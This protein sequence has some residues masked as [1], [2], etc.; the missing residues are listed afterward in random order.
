MSRENDC[1]ADWEIREYRSGDERRLVKLFAKVYRRPLSQEVW[2]WK[3]KASASD[4]ENVWLA[5][6]RE[7]QTIF[8]IAGIPRRFLLD[9]DERSL[10]LNVDAMTDPQYQRRGLLT[11]VGRQAYDSW[12]AAGVSLVLGLPN[13]RWGT[14]TDALGWRSL[15]PLRWR[16]LPLRPESILA[17]RL[18]IPWPGKISLLGSVWKAWRGLRDRSTRRVT[19]RRLEEAGTELDTLWQGLQREARI[20]LARDRRW[21]QWRY[22]DH[23]ELDYRVLLAETDDRPCAYAAYRV[24]D[25]P[26]GRFGFV[27]ELTALRANESAR[28]AVLSAAVE[29]MR[30]EGA[31]AVAALA[32][33]AT[34]LDRLLRRSGFVF[35]RGAF[36]VRYV[37][38]DPR[39]PHAALQDPD[40]WDLQGGDFD[41]V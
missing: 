2:R 22:L 29:E 23:P 3:L 1:Q 6:D 40:N 41:V 24:A 12:A 26:A 9:G 34:D 11:S 10:M 37:P 7:G 8:Q 17:R 38:L 18:G 21:V 39:L 20:T 36:Q 19:T 4:V 15:F 28:R 25:V 16:Y 5:V 33:P 32:V 14:R 31:E 30:A 35:R 13:E 27:A